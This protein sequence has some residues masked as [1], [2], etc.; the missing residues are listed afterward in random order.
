MADHHQGNELAVLRGG[1]ELRVI[2]HVGPIMAERIIVRLPDGSCW[3]MWFHGTELVGGQLHYLV[4][5]ASRPGEVLR[6]PEQWVLIP[7]EGGGR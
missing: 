4:E 7:G 2:R 6:V 3:Y 5:V 1:P